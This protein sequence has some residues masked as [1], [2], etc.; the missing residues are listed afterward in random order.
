MHIGRLFFIVSAIAVAVTSFAAGCS[1]K[2]IPHTAIEDTPRNREVVDLIERYRQALQARDTNAILSLA[3]NKY[4]DNSGTASPKD[5]IDYKGLKQF[6]ADHLNKVQASQ[7]DFRVEQVIEDEDNENKLYVEYRYVSRYQLEMP[8][9]Q[10]QWHVDPDVR[11]RLT[12]IK[13]GGD[14]RILSGL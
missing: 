13:E 12:L 2:Y 9:G 14:W 10:Q 4:Y 5:D 3:S 6:L 1:T 8:S 7:V 11:D